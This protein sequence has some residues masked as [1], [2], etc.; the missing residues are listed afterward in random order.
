MSLLARAGLA[1]LA[2]L[3]GCYDPSLPDCTVACTNGD[4]CGPGQVCGDDG[5]CAA[6]DVADACDERPTP[7]GRPPDPVT[8]RIVIERRGRVEVVSPEASCESDERDGETCSVTLPAPREITLR[9]IQTDEPFE[10]WSGLGC[11]G[12][13]PTCDATLGPGTHQVTARFRN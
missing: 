6:P 13:M 11:S 3:A 8:L 9:A 12:N 7:D 2:A 5:L 4:E 1:A 10:R